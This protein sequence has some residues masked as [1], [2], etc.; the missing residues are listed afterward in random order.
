MA[1]MSG[2][3]NTRCQIIIVIC[4]GTSTLGHVLLERF[5]RFAVVVITWLIDVL[6]PTVHSMMRNMTKNDILILMMRVGLRTRVVED[7][8]S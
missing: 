2:V 5:V 6:R 7:G 8:H 1:V 4:V 3:K